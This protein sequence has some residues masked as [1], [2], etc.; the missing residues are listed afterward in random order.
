MQVTERRTRDRIRSLRAPFG[1]AAVVAAA[2]AYLAV[3]D[4]NQP[5][6]YPTCPLYFLTGLYCPGCGA[7]RAVHDLAHGDLA[8]ALGMNALFVICVP[9]VIVGWA[10]W[11]LRSWQGR[12]ARTRTV[13][14]ALLWVLTAIVIAYGVVRN[15]PFGHFLAP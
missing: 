15:V 12:P 10:D 14:P 4:P 7:L 9:V 5:G 3:V 6:H 13:H 8:G 1:A 2:A 11:A